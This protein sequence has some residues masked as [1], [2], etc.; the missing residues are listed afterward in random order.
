M[1]GKK[2]DLIAR[3]LDTDVEASKKDADE[4]LLKALDDAINTEEDNG[5]E[6]SETTSTTVVSD[7][8]IS[9]F[10]NLGISKSLLDSVNSQGWEEPTPIQ[11]LAIPEILEQFKPNGNV[12]SLWAE[13]PTG[14]GK[15]G[16][17][18]IP[19]IQLTL[20]N[21]KWYRNLEIEQNNSR[22]N[23]RPIRR[24]PSHSTNNN[25]QTKGFVETLI[26][27]PTRELALQIGGVFEELVEGM[28]SSDKERDNIDVVVVTG[29]LPIEPQ[30][31]MLA[32]RKRNNRNVDFLI[33]TPGRLADVL[34]RS[35]KENSVERELEK[36]LMSALDQA[37]GKHDTSLSLSQLEDLDINKVLED[38]DDGGRSAIKDMISNVKYLVVDEADRLLSPGFKKETDEVF[39]LLPRSNSEQPLKTL[40]FS[41]TFPEQIQ[42]RV[43]KVLHRLSGKDAPPPLR[44]SCATAG[45][46]FEEGELSTRKRKLRERTTQPR[47]ILEGPSSTIDV[48]SIRID[49]KDRTQALRRLINQH[50]VTRDEEGWDR[51]LVFVGTRYASEHVAMKLRKYN[52]RAS[53]L[54]GKLD[55]DARVRRLAD[56]KKGKIKVLIAT[57]LAS[58][59]L[60]VQG[61][62][63][64]VNYDLPRS[65][66]DFVHRIGRTGRAGNKG[67]AVTFVT[68]SNEA[69]YD[70]IEKR[71]LGSAVKREILPGF[72]PNEATWD[73]K[74]SAASVVVEGVKHSDSGLAHDKMFGGIKG[75]KK[76]KKDKLREKAARE[77]AAAE[78]KK[79]T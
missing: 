74:R 27:C 18:C 33:A 7:S 70:L 79:L 22:S 56:F 45:S 57:D 13:A 19:L 67:T 52:I 42:P 4:V 51:I 26:L 64:V 76:S 72:E 12:R 35:T 77:A 29:G 17:F 58:R 2:S 63:A 23:Q 36:R 66:A 69:H 1:S 25:E 20:Q 31:Q 16:A 62:P 75:R 11:K 5:Q 54:H 60:D 78:K 30:V 38:G 53:E 32:E 55:Q 34:L 37:G 47:A 61:L 3:L 44:L 24:R 41:A 50:D 71:H 68:P 73:F 49:D 46:I 40:L 15:T 39:Q 6:E 59:G 9:T 28:P 48:R 43:E 8:D 10:D 65:T 14:S 21:R